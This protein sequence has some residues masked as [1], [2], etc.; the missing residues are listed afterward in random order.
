VKREQRNTEHTS[1]PNVGLYE[2]F[3]F[4]ECELFLLNVFMRT[5]N[6]LRTDKTYT[7]F[8]NSFI[9][10]MERGPLSLVRI[11][12]ELFQGNSGCGLENR[13]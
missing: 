9:E 5:K 1:M 6:Q 12:E 11:T 10:A 13:D 3:V 2:T 7:T 8:D 4:H